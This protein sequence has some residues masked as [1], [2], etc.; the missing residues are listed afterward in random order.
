M[1]ICVGEE[2][3]DKIWALRE[4]FEKHGMEIERYEKKDDEGTV[5]ASNKCLAITKPHCGDGRDLSGLFIDVF[6]YTTKRDS[7]HL[8][9]TYGGEPD[10]YNIEDVYPVQEV[11]FGPIRAC[12]PANPGA[13]NKLVFGED[14]MRVARSGF[15]DH[16]AVGVSLITRQKVFDPS[17]YLGIPAETNY[18]RILK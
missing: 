16:M 4:Q 15:F 8:S 6:F 5:I 13:I 18:T 11:Q 1:D 3:R 17:A 12:V 7:I 2:D 14:C 9:V 10:C